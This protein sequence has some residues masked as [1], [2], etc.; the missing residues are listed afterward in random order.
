ML[1]QCT[2]VVKS[3]TGVC[4]G[5]GVTCG[6]WQTFSIRKQSGIGLSLLY[7]QGGCRT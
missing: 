5:G 1:Q 4:V 7:F 6:D 2:Q 3:S